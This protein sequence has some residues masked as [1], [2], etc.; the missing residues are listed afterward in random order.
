MREVDFVLNS[1]LNGDEVFTT[2]PGREGV[3]RLS[4]LPPPRRQSSWLCWD[5]WGAPTCGAVQVRPYLTQGAVRQAPNST[6]RWG[7]LLE[8]RQAPPSAV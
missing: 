2:C 3:V 6:G 1:L 4:S 7:D 5:L 8:T